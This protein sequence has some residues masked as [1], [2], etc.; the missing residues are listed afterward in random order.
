MF[1]GF[2]LGALTVGLY[3][4]ENVSFSASV[5]KYEI[6][7]TELVLE[8]QLGR[9]FTSIFLVTYLPTMIINIINQATNYLD[10]QNF[11]EAIITV[12][13][14][15]LMV[16][17]ALYISVS[18]SL[19]ATSGIKNIDVWLLFSLIFPFLI[20]L[21]NIVIFLHN[22]RMLAKRLMEPVGTHG[23]KHFTSGRRLGVS[24][25]SATIYYVLPFIYVSFIV[26]YFIVGLYFV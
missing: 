10:N 14:T 16:L 1:R 25:L 5:S 3:K 13:I 20:I 15:S 4:V 24:L 2:Y 8:I 23:N 11:L 21:F 19:P 18:S 26:V 22:K 7:R 9:D 17:S 6:N 12:N